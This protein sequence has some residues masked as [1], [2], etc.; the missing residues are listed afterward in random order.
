[1][2]TKERLQEFVDHNLD[3]I[4]QILPGGLKD[5]KGRW[6]LV[7]PM[8]ERFNL[9]FSKVKSAKEVKSVKG[10]APA[11]PVKRKSKKK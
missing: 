6:L 4:A 5:A 3:L 8:M 2:V 7:C 11:K 9:D 10:E 1:M